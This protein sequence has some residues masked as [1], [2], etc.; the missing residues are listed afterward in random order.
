[1]KA[2][3]SMEY[4]LVVGLGFLLIIPIIL[5]A[6]TQSSRFSNDVTT[7]QIQKVGTEL[8]DAINSVYYAGPPTKKTMKLYFPD[9]INNITIQGD[10]L[11]FSVR[12]RGGTY[13]YVAF[14]ATNM[15]GSIE[16]FDGIH[17]LVVEASG[18]VVNVTDG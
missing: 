9:G 8:V 12:G 17:N 1:M 15:T 13:E 10:K 6:Y 3:V 5:I 7:A 4:L 14:A 16:P 18:S 2:Q 11:I